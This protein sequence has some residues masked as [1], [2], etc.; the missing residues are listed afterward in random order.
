MRCICVVSTLFR[1][2]P[3]V[4]VSFSNS[5][6][7]GNEAHLRSTLLPER[8]EPTTYQK[9]DGNIKLMLPG[10]AQTPA[11]SHGEIFTFRRPGGRGVVASREEVAADKLPL[12]PLFA[13]GAHDAVGAVIPHR[14]LIGGCVG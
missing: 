13:V 6:F 5:L 2:S 1:D 12:V 10:V 8:S 11:N 4:D 9:C 14:L 7:L 3:K